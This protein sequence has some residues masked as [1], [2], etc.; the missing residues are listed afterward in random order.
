M[1]N[2]DKNE[3]N[4]AGNGLPYNS[5]PIIQARDESGKK[6]EN[7]EPVEAVLSTKR[8]IPLSEMSLLP[9]QFMG[10][11]DYAQTARSG[12]YL[13]TSMFH[14]KWTILLVFIVIAVPLLAV[15]WTQ[16]IP[17]YQARAE[18]RVRPIIPF[19]VFKSENS[20]MI[21]LYTS[22]MNTQVSIIRSPT[23]L[24][25]VL[26]KQEIRDT[27]WLKMPHESFLSKLRGNKMTTMERLR[28]N[29]SV[30]PRNQTEIIDVSFLAFDAEE[31][32]I[33]INAVLDEYRYYI[34]NESD[35][36]ERILFD[37]LQ[38]EHNSLKN[39]I[40]GQEKAIQQR[41]NLLGTSSPQ[42]L[43][44][45]KRLNIEQ[46]QQQLSEVEQS[47][48]ILD[49]ERKKIEE[50]VITDQNGDSN[51]TSKDS[52]M[53]RHYY[54]DAEWRSLD[55]E[56]RTMKH[57]IK[58]SIFT[59]NHPEMIKLQGNLKFAEEML[60]LHESRLDEQ[61]KNRP[62]TITGSGG[63]TLL[64]Y[65]EQ[66]KNIDY[67]KELAE[68]RKKNLDENLKKQREEFEK[69]FESAQS[70]ERETNDLAYKR[71]LFDVVRQRLDQKNM[72]RNVPGSIEVLTQAFASSQYYNDRRAVFSMMVLC[73]AFGIGCA[74]AFL[75]ASMN[76]VIY[77][78]ADMPLPTRIP[79]LGS[80]P[81]IRLK[82]SIGKALGEEIEM[83]QILLFESV[84]VIRTKLLSQLDS[85]NSSTVLIS[86]ST[87]GTGKSSFTKILGKCMAKTGKKVLMIDVDFYKTTLSKRF[88]LADK[89]GILNYLNSKSLDLNC[90]YQTEMQN[91]SV[92]PAGR[93][94]RNRIFFEGIDNGF[95]T[96]YLDELRK[97]YSIIIL[98]GSPVLPR[99]DTA[100]MSRNVNGIIMVERELVSRR[101]NL[102]NS[103][104]RINS[105]GGYIWGVVFVG[106]GG[107]E[108]Y[109]YDYNVPS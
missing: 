33:I 55:I 84:R 16:I 109:D 66:L 107:Y 77:S 88:G 62:N 2:I 65:E 12:N 91:L 85:E 81:L 5:D 97:H 24:Q 104:E 89:P 52:A 47:I 102:I 83:N 15:I 94:D 14:F 3:E 92:M 44:A 108:K 17:K 42:E 29:L 69:V 30:R 103:I 72:E 39:E 26:E 106:S 64:S 31:A 99:A 74:A 82:N 43:V 46:I 98:D 96:T 68:E 63:E 35:V 70:L 34:K 80:V 53:Q 45:S 87:A 86:S 60:Q 1:S 23:V 57:Q 73:L 75:R 36:T 9:G 13:I 6:S 10:A 48:A 50:L 76:Q 78:S 93:H 61:W 79:N 28:D 8:P 40:L 51:D 27:H 11:R 22:F 38:E 100:I 56:I 71:Q 18:I 25:R 90:I 58:F 21:P 37:Q 105:S 4:F 54:E 7:I 20:G 95:F 19:L 101:E 49:W 32:K 67:R 59:E 41:L